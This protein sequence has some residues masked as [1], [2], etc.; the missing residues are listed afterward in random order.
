MI[1]CDGWL[2]HKHLEAVHVAGLSVEMMA[3]QLGRFPSTVYRE[4]RHNCCDN[5]GYS[6]LV[7]QRR[8]DQPTRHPKQP[9]LT[10]DPEL[11]AKVRERQV[12]RWSPHASSA[13]LR[14]EGH[15][16]CAETIYAA[17]L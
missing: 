12:M 4:L 16:I 1:D 2:C 9:K 7:A 8:C 5:G 6:A 13:D 14:V 3:R 15:R 10:T 11:A 17:L